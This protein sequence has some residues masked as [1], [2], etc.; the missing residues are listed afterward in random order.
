MIMRS[1]KLTLATINNH[2]DPE[3][4][5]LAIMINGLD[6]QIEPGDFNNPQLLQS[7][8]F[9]DTPF[10]Y[11]IASLKPMLLALAAEGLLVAYHTDDLP[12]G[13][14]ADLAFV[15]VDLWNEW[16]KECP[17]LQC[18]RERFTQRILNN[19]VTRFEVAGST[20]EINP[21][22]IPIPIT[23]TTSNLT[24]YKPPVKKL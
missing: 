19:P 17:G 1:V 8:L 10:N 18:T 7:I 20:V 6:Q 3:K 16:V 12:Q 13:A 21:Q 24:R 2:P 4:L 14:T 9:E 15:G 22:A 23:P 11:S 5:R